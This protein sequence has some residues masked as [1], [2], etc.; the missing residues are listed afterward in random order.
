M[1][2]LVVYIYIG[3]RPVT[4]NNRKH[5]NEATHKKMGRHGG[6]SIRSSK[7]A[8]KCRKRIC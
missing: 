1:I 6:G 7:R 4:T 8:S 5:S 2:T 3:R